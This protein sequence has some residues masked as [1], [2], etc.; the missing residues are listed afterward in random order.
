TCSVCGKSF[1]CSSTLTLHMRT[2]T[3]EKPFPCSVC[4][5]SFSRSSNLTQH[6][7]THARDQPTLGGDGNALTCALSGKRDT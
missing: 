7:S 2:H 5:K 1:I 6:M 4:G 3:G